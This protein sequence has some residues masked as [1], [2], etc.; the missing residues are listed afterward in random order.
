MRIILD[1]DMAD[2]VDDV[3]DH[4]MIWTLAKQGKLNVLALDHFI[5]ERLQRSDSLCDCQIL[6]P[7]EHSH[8][9]VPRQIPNNYSYTFSYYAQ[10][11]AAKFGKGSS[12][13]RANYPD[14]VTVYRQALVS[15]PNASVYI[16]AGGFFQPLE[17]LLQ[18]GPD[19]ISPLTGAQL[20]AQKVAALVPVAGL[21]PGSSE[22]RLPTFV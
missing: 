9:R 18:S 10:N 22:Q 4:A 5:H 13:T 20:V 11:V 7:L 6:W 14:A 12:D 2:D 17:A 19:S 16:V 21:F 3:G 15:A 1:S 8:R